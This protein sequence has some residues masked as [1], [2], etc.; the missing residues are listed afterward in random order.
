MAKASAVK[1]PKFTRGF[2]GGGRGRPV[3]PTGRPFTHAFFR[4]LRPRVSGEVRER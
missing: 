3:V 4:A 1:A 2:H